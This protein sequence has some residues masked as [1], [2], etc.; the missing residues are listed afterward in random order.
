M[1][2]R[3]PFT[4]KQP[5]LSHLVEKWRSLDVARLVCDRSS[6]NASFH[7][8]TQGPKQRVTPLSVVTQVAQHLG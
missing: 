8:N 7:V 2:G 3:G 5:R 6:S 1:Q 4:W